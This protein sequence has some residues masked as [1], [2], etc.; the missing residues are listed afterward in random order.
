MIMLSLLRFRTYVNAV[1]KGFDEFPEIDSTV[2]E[3]VTDNYENCIAYL[4]EQLRILDPDYFEEITAKTRKLC[5][6]RNE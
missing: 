4:Q 6:T 2:R 3:D 5:R 1:L